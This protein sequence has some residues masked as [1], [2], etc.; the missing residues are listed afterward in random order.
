MT[1]LMSSHHPRRGVAERPTVGR[2][3]GL[4]ADEVDRGEKAMSLSGGGSRAALFPRGALPRLKELGLRART[5][6]VGAVAGGSIVA[7]LL[8]TRVP[9][10]LHGAS[11]DWP[12][13]AAEPL[14][15]SASRNVR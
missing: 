13:R 11:R 8:A 14:R 12:E 7:A 1:N 5:G 9:W 2:L 3:G 10:P 6:T 4:A 15:E